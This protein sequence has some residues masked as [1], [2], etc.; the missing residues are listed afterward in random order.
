MVWVFVASRRT[1]EPAA[2]VL[3]ASAFWERE[4]SNG[5]HS[6]DRTHFKDLKNPFDVQLPGGD[7]RFISLPVEIFREHIPFTPLDEPPLNICHCPAIESIS[8]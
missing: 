4:V 3:V 8:Y 2:S 6:S 7:R 1:P 5:H